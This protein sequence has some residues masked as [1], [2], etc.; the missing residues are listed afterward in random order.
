MTIVAVVSD[1]HD[2]ALTQP[3]QPTLYLPYMQT[4][5]VLWPAIQRSLVIVARTSQDVQTMSKP[6]HQ[7]V[8][9]VDSSLP[10]AS[11]HTLD[12]F[13]ATSLATERFNT[14]LLLTLGAVALVL[15]SVGIYGVVSY[16]VS[17]RTQEIGL[18]TALGALPRH[19]WRLVLGRGLAP[20]GA[21]AV[22]GVVLSL[23]T[24][25]LL[26][27]QLFGVAP[28]DPLTLGGVVALLAISAV[29][30]TLQPARR[31]M[32]VAPIVALHES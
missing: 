8:M 6:I 19:I 3:V 18:R 28:A 27:E 29:L 20:I 11:S 30:A 2:A 15:A 26:R 24:A 10:F 7:A 21:G 5:G 9:S 22:I 17:Q 16:F 31:A 1:V 12:E 4:P 14:L 23:A 13:L 25:R 32:R